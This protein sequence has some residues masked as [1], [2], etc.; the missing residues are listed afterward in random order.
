MEWSISLIQKNKY[1]NRF[2]KWIL[3]IKPIET[4]ESLITTFFAQKAFHLD[5]GL[6]KEEQ[7]V[8]FDI[9]ANDSINEKDSLAKLDTFF[10]NLTDRYTEGKD[11]F[12]YTL[13]KDI[14]WFTLEE[15]KRYIDHYKAA[16]N[17]LILAVN[18]LLKQS[19]ITI[20]DFMASHQE[21]L[22]STDEEVKK[23][24]H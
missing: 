14:S 7:E 19:I 15:Y 24:L 12:F 3:R 9:I 13:R 17:K 4:I 20:H 18:E 2:F 1:L 22:D 16:E 23:T 11:E 8:L 10:V 21:Y 5:E 6:T